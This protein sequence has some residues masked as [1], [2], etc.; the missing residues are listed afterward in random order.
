MTS[1]LFLKLIGICLSNVYI[2]NVIQ[3]STVAIVDDSIFFKHELLKNNVWINKNEIPN[4]DIDDDN[5]GFVDDIYGANFIENNGNVLFNENWYTKFNP[6]IYQILTYFT[7]SQ[8]NSITEQD[9][10]NFNNI[11]KN[12]SRDEYED[13]FTTQISD[14]K[15]LSHATH[16]AGIVVKQNKKVNIMSLS[17]HKNFLPDLSSALVFDTEKYNNNDEYYQAK[18]KSKNAFIAKIATYITKQKVDVANFSIS[19]SLFYLIKGQLGYNA[20]DTDILKDLNKVYSYFKILEKEW[21]TNAKNTLFVF[22]AGNDSK[23]IDNYFLFPNTIEAENAITVGSSEN[24]K[25]KKR[26]L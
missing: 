12:I 22:A 3:A 20:T 6:N 25:V 11:I 2:F 24:I 19:E 16:C 1:K 10:T 26:N 9:Q 8:I 5:N 23:N 13:I 4:N 18:A 15:D 17:L 14:F 7:K 21:L